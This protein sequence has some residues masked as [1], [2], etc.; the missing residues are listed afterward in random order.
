MKDLIIRQINITEIKVSGY[1][2]YSNGEFIPIFVDVLKGLAKDCSI[3][4]TT[5]RVLLFVLTIVD[6]NNYVHININEIAENMR[7]GKTSVYN[8][9]G[10]LITMNILC[11][12]TNHRS[13]VKGKFKLNIYVLNPRVGYRGN[14]RKIN[15][16][17]AP[18]IMT[19]D[20]KTP[21]LLP[22]QKHEFD[23]TWHEQLQ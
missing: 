15:K 10:S 4:P 5:L 8:A 16:N 11:D 17:L 14:T 19:G 3:K 7:L 6:K 20:G 1:E 23:G 2:R 22:L 13:K 18:A 21:L 9:I 12:D